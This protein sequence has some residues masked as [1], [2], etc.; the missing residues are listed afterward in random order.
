MEFHNFTIDLNPPEAKIFCDFRPPQARFLRKSENLRA[1]G[2]IFGNVC[3]CIVK[4]NDFDDNL[5]E[6]ADL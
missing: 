4:S 2:K 6:V 3:R 1:A 5:G